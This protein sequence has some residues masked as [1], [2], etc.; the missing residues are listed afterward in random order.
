LPDKLSQT[1]AALSDVTR[2]EILAR[3]IEGDASV[4]ELALP[5]DMTV[6]A[7]SKHVAV[8][9]A[10]GLVTRSKDSQRRPSKIRAMP[11]QE[12]DTWLAPYKALWIAAEDKSPKFDRMAKLMAK[13]QNRTK[14]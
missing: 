8:L 9:E 7:V 2:R 3:L 11:L 1:F 10:A 13:H 12:I 6:R 5:F 14:E 4:N